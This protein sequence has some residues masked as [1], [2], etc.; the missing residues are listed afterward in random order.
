[1]IVLDG[2]GLLRVD[3]IDHE[4]VPSALAYVAHGR[5]RSI[6]AGP[7]GLTYLTAHRSRGPLRV[8]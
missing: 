1:M 2:N 8:N 6:I 4:V 3:E 7:D 5:Q